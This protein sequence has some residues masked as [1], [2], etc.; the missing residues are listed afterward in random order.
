VVVGEG[1]EKK[2]VLHLTGSRTAGVVGVAPTLMAAEAA[3]E[4]EVRAAPR[5]FPLVLADC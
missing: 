3:A 4:A 2:K 1:D 5:L